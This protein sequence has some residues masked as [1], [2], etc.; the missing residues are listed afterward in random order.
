[1]GR[2]GSW[3]QSRLE[4]RTQRIMLWQ[5]CWFCWWTRTSVFLCKRFAKIW[6]ICILLPWNT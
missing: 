4:R 5:R 2:P 6:H 1:V 3:F